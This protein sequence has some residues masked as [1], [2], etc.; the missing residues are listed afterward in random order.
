MCVF[1]VLQEG[2]SLTCFH[3]PCT[4]HLLQALQAAAEENAVLSW[5]TTAMMGGKTR[6]QASKEV[7]PVR[8]TAHV[9][10]ILHW[11]EQAARRHPC[12][13]WMFLEAWHSRPSGAK[14]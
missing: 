9:I 4:P 8:I 12:H 13:A 3:A 5:L 6:I 1:R 14:N 2:C 7:R 11:C 10:T